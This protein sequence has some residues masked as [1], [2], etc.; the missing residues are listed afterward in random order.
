MSQFNE[1]LLH[2]YVSYMFILFYC[3]LLRIPD[4]VQKENYCVH[5]KLRASSIQFTALWPFSHLLDLKS[6]F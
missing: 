4:D 3:T 5:E 2:I 1:H 6:D